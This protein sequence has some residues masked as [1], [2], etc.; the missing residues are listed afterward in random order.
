MTIPHFHFT[1]DVDMTS[2]LTMKKNMADEPHLRGLPFTLLPILVK[3]LSAV[4]LEFPEVNSSLSEDHSELIIH[5]AHH[6]GI[7][8][9]TDTGLVVPN[10]KNVQQKTIVDIAHELYNL[11]SDA[12]LDCLK[13]EDLQGGTITVSNIGSVGSIHAT[14]LIVPPQTAIVAVGRMRPV[15][16]VKDSKG[17]PC[18]LTDLQTR[19]M[20]PISWGADHRVLDG[21][22]LVE[23][24]NRW[25]QFLEHPERLLL[26]LK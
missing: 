9:A 24:S 22:C 8:M 14:P 20:M 15:L 6:I 11:K 12:L 13:P 7:A 23:F 19:S 3:S 2:L 4:L 17:V 5:S 16:R 10:V 18:S 21:A 26:F 1:D 25:K